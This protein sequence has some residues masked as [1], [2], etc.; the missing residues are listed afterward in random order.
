MFITHRKSRKVAAAP[1]VAPK[2]E[3]VVEVKQ[4][5][6]EKVIEKPSYKVV[7]KKKKIEEEEILLK[8]LFLFDE[9]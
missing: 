3:P 9:E 1:V 5:P 4:E 6:V 8:D 7:P 2:A